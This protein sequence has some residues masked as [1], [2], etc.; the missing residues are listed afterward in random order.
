MCQISE[1]ARVS[2]THIAL[3]VYSGLLASTDELTN[4]QTKNA[5]FLFKKHEEITT[6]LDYV[7]NRFLWKF[8]YRREREN[9]RPSFQK[10]PKK[11]HGEK[12]YFNLLSIT[13]KKANKM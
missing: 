3:S 10:N 13:L 4:K 8:V 9:E 11:K 2:E 7:T 6:V 1:Q 12:Q 5:E